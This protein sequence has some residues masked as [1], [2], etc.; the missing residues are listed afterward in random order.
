LIKVDAAAVPDRV[1]VVGDPNR[2][3]IVAQRLQNV[4]ELGRNREY[5]TVAGSYRG[6]RIGVASHG[7]GAP[8][9]ALCFEEL[10]QAG[11]QRLIRAGT[12]GGLA[13]GVEEGDLVVVTGAVRR[14]G[15]TQRVVPLGYPAIA[16]TDVVL[17]LREAA[18][19]RKVKFHEGLTVTD[20]L[21]YAHPMLGNELQLWH[22]AGVAA[23]EMECSALLILASLHGVQ[24]GAILTVDAKDLEL[25][26]MTAYNP[27]RTNIR[28]AVEAMIDVSLDALVA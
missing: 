10:C 6:R 3:A 16:T 23:I 27:H 11:A 4:V 14:E 25:K 15:F 24:A 21:F 20:D 8:G 22:D 7:V 19:A 28:D 5:V 12:C 9:A 13:D 18:L 1:L 17:R 26:D 2:V